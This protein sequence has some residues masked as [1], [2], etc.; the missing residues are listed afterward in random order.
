MEIKINSKINKSTLIVPVFEQEDLKTKLLDV[1]KLIGFDQW[2]YFDDFKGKAK[3]N[4]LFIT[5][6]GEKGYFLGLGKNREQAVIKNTFRSFFYTKKEKLNG[7]VRV[8]LSHENLE[9]F[10]SSISNGI[11]LANYNLGAQKKKEPSKSWF[12][13]NAILDFQT[14]LNNDTLIIEF[15]KGIAL[16]KTQMKIMEWVDAPSNY[17]TPRMI[18]DWIKESGKE[19]GFEVKI[20]DNNICVDLGLKALVAVGKGS[21]EN[22]PIFVLMEYSHP[23]AS[24]TIGLIGKGV[25]FDTGGVSLKPGDNMN[26]MKCDMGGAAAVVGAIEMAAKL[27][28][29][30]NIVAAVPLTEN[31]IDSLAIKPGD[32]IGSYSGK[33]IEVINTDAEGRLI[34]A[35]ALSYV[36]KNYNPDI[37]IDLA[38]LTG[39]CIQSLGYAAA[40]L[41]SN[42][43]DLANAILASGQKT[44][45]KT[46][47]MPLW[48][49]YKDMMKSDVADIKNLSSAPVAGAITAAKFLEEF[50]DGHTSWAHLDIAGV[51]FGDSEYS[52]MKSATGYGVQLLVDF[53]ENNIA[54]NK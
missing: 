15:E 46:W 12:L 42:N 9:E 36:K 34:L 38:T 1:C 51:A 23:E 35:D 28:L 53:I 21:V 11:A 18:S 54:S 50:I 10:A 31:C 52:S 39:N 30:I 37:L 3:E 47:R 24:K 32:V 19:Y 8:L 48:D 26:Y 22:P 49:D 16:A 13:E 6:S 25:T 2:S 29:M 4:C 17:K 5:S 20:F 7:T 33:T 40:A 41:L 43:D 44:G 45:E 14:D 27:K